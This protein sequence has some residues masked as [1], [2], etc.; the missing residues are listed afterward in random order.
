MCGVQGIWLVLTDLCA[1]GALALGVRMP[2]CSKLVSVLPSTHARLR[3]VP[4]R[5][6]VLATTPDAHPVTLFVV[7]LLVSAPAQAARCSARV[8]S[9]SGCS[10]LCSPPYIIPVLSVCATVWV[11]G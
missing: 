9:R 2:D 11:C 8:G 3:L 5:L 7:A 4:T 6:G 1:W 10:R